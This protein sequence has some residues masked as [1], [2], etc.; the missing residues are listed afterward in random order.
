MIPARL[1]SVLSA[2][3]ITEKSFKSTNK[4]QDIYKPRFLDK[5]K[6]ISTQKIQIM[7]ATS[8]RVLNRI[9]K[10]F[11]QIEVLDQ[12]E[13]DVLFIMINGREYERSLNNVKWTKEKI[14]EFAT[15]AIRGIKKARDQE[16]ITRFRSSF[17][18]RFSSVLE[19][20]DSSLFFLRDAREKFKDV[21][22]VRS[23][24]KTVIIAGF[25]NVGKSSLIA[26]ITNLKPEIAE[27]AFTTKKI[28]Q[29]VMV[30]GNDTYEVLDVP[31]LLNREDHNS[32]ERKALA[33][34]NNIGDILICL[35]DPTEQCGYSLKEQLILSETLKNEGKKVLI[36]EN[37]SDLMKT[38][39]ENLKI[40][41]MTGDGIERLQEVI[42]ERIYER[43]D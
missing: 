37:K 41:C 16:S 31:G 33:A 32:I 21:P 12:F 34:I 11:P 27:Y 29:G 43:E 22:L 20:L 1:P 25:P 4:I 24:L 19:N 2:K 3:E 15:K 10:G 9:Y 8:R 39:S 42:R 7:E 36:V 18:G 14:S 23:D 35:I 28:N 30:F 40:S 26:R 38:E 13:R 6:I 17:Y 5:L